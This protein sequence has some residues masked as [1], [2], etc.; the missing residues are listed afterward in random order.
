[1]S[2]IDF[3]AHKIVDTDLQNF[4][5]SSTS[6]ERRSVIVEL[7][8][9]SPHIPLRPAHP[10]Y[11]FPKLADRHTPTDMA[12]IEGHAASMDQLEKKF[13]ALDLATKP[14][15]LDAAQAFVVSVTPEQLR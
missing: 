8:L 5:A 14:V 1:M 2:M 12:D 6:D 3:D 10:P 11:A 15:R 7:G 4:A 13:N 9:P